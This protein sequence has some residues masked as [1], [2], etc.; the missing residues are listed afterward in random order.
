MILCS[1]VIKLFPIRNMSWL[2]QRNN[3]FKLAYAALKNKIPNKIQKTFP[4]FTLNKN[5][6]IW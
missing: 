4:T 6:Q 2:S 1:T 3:T 5:S